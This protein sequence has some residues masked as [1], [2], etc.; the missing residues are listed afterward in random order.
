MYLVHSIT[1]TFT[2]LLQLRYVHIYYHVYD[3]LINHQGKTRKKGIRPHIL[4]IN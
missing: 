3:F 4:T 1:H 2:K